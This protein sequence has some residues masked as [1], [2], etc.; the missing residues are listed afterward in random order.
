[1]V[2][3]LDLPFPLLS[4]LRGDLIKRL[5]LWSEKEGVSEPAVVILDR[6]RV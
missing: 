5:D 2:E 6:G 3:K 1:M 4:D